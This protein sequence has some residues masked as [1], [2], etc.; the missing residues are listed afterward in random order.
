[1][2]ELEPRRSSGHRRKKRR[3]PSYQPPYFR[4]SSDSDDMMTVYPVSVQ[5]SQV[6][7]DRLLVHIYLK[8]MDI[9][10]CFTAGVKNK[11][12]QKIK[13]FKPFSSSGQLHIQ[14][15]EHHHLLHS[16]LPESGTLGRLCLDLVLPPPG[17]SMFSPAAD[18]LV[19]LR[20]DAQSF[21]MG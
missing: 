14:L 21:E 2:E 3:S 13:K 19:V 20:A 12:M 15:T 9:I 17:S 18:H 7:Q 16:P 10:T 1:M 8:L 5:D 11:Y 6:P 4:R